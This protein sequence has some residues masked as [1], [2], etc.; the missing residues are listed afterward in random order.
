MADFH[1]Y[2]STGQICAPVLRQA[3]LGLLLLWVLRNTYALAGSKSKLGVYVTQIGDGERNAE[4]A[5][6]S[7]CFLT[8]SLDK[9]L[10]TGFRPKS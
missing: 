9:T 6:S 8:F 7:S 10:P 2:T 3:R 1:R 4:D 5:E